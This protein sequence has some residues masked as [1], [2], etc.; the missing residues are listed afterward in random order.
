MQVGQMR[1][2]VRDFH[3]RRTHTPRGAGGVSNFHEIHKKAI[4]IDDE[5]LSQQADKPLVRGR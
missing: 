3:Y 4:I 2:E 5:S 1:R